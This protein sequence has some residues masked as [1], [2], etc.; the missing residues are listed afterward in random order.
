[1]DIE[2]EKAK[3][4]LDGYSIEQIEKAIKSMGPGGW[5]D[6]RKEVFRG[7]VVLEKFKDK[8]TMK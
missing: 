8:L 5:D 7:F 2:K 6:T 1:M 4:L 3:L